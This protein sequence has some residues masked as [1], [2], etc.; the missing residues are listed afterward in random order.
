MA[1]IEV[2]NDQLQFLKTIRQYDDDVTSNSADNQANSGNTGNAT[3]ATEDNAATTL[4]D[5]G[6]PDD[7]PS[8]DGT[9]ANESISLLTEILFGNLVL[10]NNNTA[11]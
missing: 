5:L 6:F 10:Y 7:E 8:P 4:D 11:K 1:T 2:E 3:T 9:L